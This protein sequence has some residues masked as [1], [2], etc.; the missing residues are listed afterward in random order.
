MKKI[1]EGTERGNGIR[2]RATSKARF[3]EKKGASI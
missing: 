2:L 3:F 1:I